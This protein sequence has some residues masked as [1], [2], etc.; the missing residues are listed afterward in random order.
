[1][2]N[3]TYSYI[4][5]EI[6]SHSTRCY[7]EKALF[8]PSVLAESLYEGRPM[9]TNS[10]LLVTVAAFLASFSAA[11]SFLSLASACLATFSASRTAAAASCLALAGAAAASLSAARAAALASASAS[12][13]ASRAAL[14]AARSSDVMA[15]CLAPP[16]LDLALGAFLPLHRRSGHSPSPSARLWRRSWRPRWY[17]TTR[18]EKS[19][20]S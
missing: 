4:L 9:S 6:G 11:A 2:V 16:P 13:C 20:S 15:G 8:L 17:R 7:N 19:P 18:G 3:I 1:M 5:L 14:R 10:T 12:F